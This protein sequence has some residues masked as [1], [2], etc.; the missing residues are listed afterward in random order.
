MKWSDHAP[1]T[2]ISE[3]HRLGNP[4]VKAVRYYHYSNSTPWSW[5]PEVRTSRFG[6][7]YFD[8]PETVNKLKDHVAGLTRDGVAVNPQLIWDGDRDR[9]VVARSNC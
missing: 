8:F 3:F 1:F 2:S 7:I 5:G 6:T 4:V 9:F